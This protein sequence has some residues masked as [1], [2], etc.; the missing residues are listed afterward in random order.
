MFATSGKIDNSLLK[1]FLS[2]SVTWKVKAVFIAMMLF[3][4]YF[5]FFT[6]RLYRV[7]VKFCFYCIIY[8]FTISFCFI[9]N[10]RT[11]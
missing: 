6:F 1:E 4:L 9:T 5:V 11:D 2:V 8:L 10:K 3:E 7:T